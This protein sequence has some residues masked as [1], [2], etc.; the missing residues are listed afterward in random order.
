MIQ[1]CMRILTVVEWILR[2]RG[3]VRHGNGGMQGRMSESIVEQLAVCD[4]EL[5]YTLA[6]AGFAPIS[7]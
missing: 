7:L 5:T 6:A 2:K 3:C 4:V 1:C